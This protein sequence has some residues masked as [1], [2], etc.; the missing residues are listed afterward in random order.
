[1]LYLVARFDDA[2]TSELADSEVS[3]DIVF[4]TEEAEPG[5]TVAVEDLGVEA[6]VLGAQIT[7]EPTVTS[8]E[9]GGE[10]LG[11]QDEVGRLV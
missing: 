10:V 6:T 11:V 5:A 1:V 4:G 3:F 9:E 8:D 2:V 7:P